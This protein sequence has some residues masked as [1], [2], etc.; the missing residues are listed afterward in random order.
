MTAGDTP[1]RSR[2]EREV[3]VTE[4]RPGTDPLRLDATTAC[5]LVLRWLGR[6]SLLNPV[7]RFSSTTSS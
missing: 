4:V 1:G 7:Y 6:S 3:T 2:V 5:G